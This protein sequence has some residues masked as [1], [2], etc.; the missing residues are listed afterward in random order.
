[1]RRHPHLY[2]V[3]ARLFI[4]RLSEKYH[5]ALTLATVPEEEWQLFA[6]RGFELVWFMGVWQRSSGA[7]QQALLDSALR[8]Q[9]DQALPGWTDED[10]AGSPYAVYNY[11]LD[12]ALGEQ[13]ELTQLK[14][15]LN[16]IGLGL[17]LDFVPNHFAFDHPWTFSHPEWFVQ[18]EETDV[19]THPDWFFLSQG[20]IHLAHG[21]DPNFLPWTDTVQVNFYSTDLRQALINEL[22]R[23]AEVA[24][25]VRCDMAM[26][27]LNDIFEKVWGKTVKGYPRPETEFWVEAIERV[28]QQR[29]DFLFLAEVYWGLERRL[30]QMGFDFTYDKP[31][32]DQLRF[33][34]T[35]GDV[36][37]HLMADDVYQLHS[38]RFIENHDEPRAVIAFGRE[39]SLAAA[40]VLATVP[41]LR[42]FHDGQL[43][44]RRIHLPIQLVREPK[45]VTDPQI[46]RFYERLLAICNAPAFHEGEWSLMEASQAREG[47]ESH[48]NLLAWLWR[49]A[50]QFKIVVV[51]YSP[52]PAHGWLK[53]VLPLESRDR[54]I[55]RDEL[56]GKTYNPA[57]N[58][59]TNRGLYVD[60][61]PYQAHLLDV[62]FD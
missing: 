15:R 9:C 5:R 17:V 10:I 50:V 22:L 18:G 32:Y 61:N 20:S 52:N 38:A 55:F 35:A 36:R 53:L 16:Q 30:Q 56:T 1:M 14:S 58:E 62:T 45:E 33:F 48:R 31:L 25:G 19:R 57:P 40:A 3:N 26:L 13:S 59:M 12:P 2:E 6:Q 43:E 7:R 27:A 29:P 28:K 4:R 44:G 54:V 60:L 23:I 34:T 41:G 47:D 51:N 49:Y 39:R 8:Q 42:L 37:S 11:N 21:R 24:D 46:L